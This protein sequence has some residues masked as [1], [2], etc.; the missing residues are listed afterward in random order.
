MLEATISEARV[1]DRRASLSVSGAPTETPFA[2][3]IF[4]ENFSAW[5]GPPLTSLTGSNIRVR[6]PL[7]VYREEPQLCLEH[8][9]QLEI[10]TDD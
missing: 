3:V 10:L 8:S 1:F 7:G 6:G 4:G 2:I 9:S 5:D